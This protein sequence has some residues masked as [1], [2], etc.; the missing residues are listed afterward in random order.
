M[1]RALSEVLEDLALGRGAPNDGGVAAGHRVLGRAEERRYARYRCIGA[2]SVLSGLAAR[3]M[4]QTLGSPADWQIEWKWDGIRGQLI[5]RSSQCFIRS[6]GEDSSRSAFPRSSKPRRGC[7]TAW[8]WMVSSWPGATVPCAFLRP[9]AAHRPEEAIGEHSA[10]RAG[11]IFS[12]MTCWNRM[13]RTSAT[14]DA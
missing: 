5:R 6:R 11:S 3:R 12:R 8:C 13:V 14:A 10:E 7:R 1:T 9:S 2:L 4:M